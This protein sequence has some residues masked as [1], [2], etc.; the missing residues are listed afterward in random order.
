MHE[1]ARNL[2]WV[3]RAVHK[4]LLSIF[5]RLPRPAR[6]L[7]THALA[8][9]FTVGTLCV[10]TRDDGAILLLQHSYRA[11]WGVPG[12]LLNRHE[13]PTTAAAREVLEETGLAITLV[14]QPEVIVDPKTRRVDLIYAATPVAGCDTTKVRPLSA[15]ITEVRWFGTGNLP[16][17]QGET[18]GALF[19]LERRR[20]ERARF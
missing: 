16:P 12:G 14:G 11:R 2:E 3:N 17:L 6:V 18:A 19:A 1:G 8:P 20:V 5:R 9:E 7:A 13:A 15:E 10:I 4:G